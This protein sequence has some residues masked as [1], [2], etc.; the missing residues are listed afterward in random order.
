MKLLWFLLPLGL[1]IASCNGDK[2][3]EN[4]PLTLRFR[5]DFGTEPL[6]MF[7]NSYSYPGGMNVRFQ[8]FLFYLSDI[9]LIKEDGSKQVLSEIALV[10]FKDVQDNATAAQGV[11]LPE[12]AVPAGTYKGIGFGVGVAPTLNGSQPGDYKAGHPLTDN[13]WSWALGYIFTKIEGNADLNGDGNFNENAKLTFHIGAN[14]LYETKRFDKSITVKA[15]EPL[16]LPFRIDLRRVLVA[17]EGNYLDFAVTRQDHTNDM[18]VAGFIMN[19]LRA[20]IIV[21]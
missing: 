21:E 5:G 18:A 19:N 9:H 20:A 8:N 16:E 2:D 13:Y 15:G 7:S 11:I 17:P 10:S 4:A 12:I 6:T 14:S 1:T 3:L